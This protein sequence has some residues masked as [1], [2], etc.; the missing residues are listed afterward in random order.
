MTATRTREIVAP[1]GVRLATATGGNPD[2]PEIL[3]IH[4]FSQCRL[5]WSRQFADPALASNFS[6][7]AFDLRGHGESDMPADTLCY[8]DDRRFADDLAA[9]I[10]G[11]KLER[12][13][14][15]A[16]SYAGRIVGDYVRAFGTSSIA[17]IVYVCARTMTDERFNGPGTIHLAGM[18]DRDLARNIAA[19]RAFLQA[20]FAV[21]P[22]REDFETALAYNMVVPP[23]VRAALL[24]RP[25]DD[26]S[27]L[28]LLDV[29]VLVIQ[30]EDDLH[31][32]K[33]LAEHMAK[34]VP[35]AELSL[36]AGIGHTPFIEA[37]PRFNTELA[38]F[39]RNRCTV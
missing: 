26:G 4:G 7:A 35:G 14:L 6:L 27:T 19:T 25:P 38:A 37:T 9:V 39:V 21:P 2:G 15:V 13:V 12:P 23:A 24:A 11:L 28:A 1:D 16:W 36:Y 33:G 32:S 17:G 29:P 30:G 34:V 10:V 22:A 8:A 3:F 5:C 18:Q 31:V 20:C